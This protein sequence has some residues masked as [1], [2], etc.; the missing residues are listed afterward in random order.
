MSSLGKLP[1][2]LPFTKADLRLP[3][4]VRKSR[5]TAR[6]DA[7]WL[8]WFT[9]L[10]AFFAVCLTAEAI[11]FVPWV[12]TTQ[13]FCICSFAVWAGWVAWRLRKR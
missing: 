5:A 12:A 8:V 9:V 7:L 3:M 10:L 2:T 4:A 6:G 1:D 13:K 11:P